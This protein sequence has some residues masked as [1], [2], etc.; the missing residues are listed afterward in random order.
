MPDIAATS[1]HAAVPSVRILGV[2]VDNVS[3]DEALALLDRFAASGQPHHVVT[4]NP[5]FV[6]QAQEHPAFRAVLEQ[7]DL[8]LADGVGL[9]WAARL[10]RRPLRA[11]LPGV[12]LLVDIA[13]MAERRG[14]RLFLLG[15]GPSV[16][17]TVAARLRARYP[18]VQ[19]VGTYGGSPDPAETAGILARVRAAQPHFLFVAYGSPAQDIWIAE[20]RAALGPVVA[21][22][23]GGSFNYL[24]GVARRA[25]AWMRRLGLEWLHRLGREPWRWR[26]MLRLPRFAGLAA[27]E[28][29]RPNAG[30]RDVPL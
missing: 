19:I 24:A 22:G 7:A 10:Q 12:D 9:M 16:A 28:A 30:G 17:D 13:G 2:R 1:Q 11:R 3:R 23:V 15:G 6:M 5:E 14:Y 25:P 8:A 20:H 27:R 18:D 29:L 26:R 21:M 4:V